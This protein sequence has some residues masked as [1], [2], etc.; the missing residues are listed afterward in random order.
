MYITFDGGEG[1]GKTTLIGRLAQTLANTEPTTD[2][3][4]LKAIGQGELG[5]H[6]R[7]AF[8][9]RELTDLEATAG[10][11]M[12]LLRVSRMAREI[13][14]ET[15]KEIYVLQDRALPAFYAIDV[16]G[17]ISKFDK[18]AF[19]CSAY[20]NTLW[21]EVKQPDLAVYLRLSPEQA[22]KN[23]TNRKNQNWLDNLPTEEHQLILDNY[24]YFFINGRQDQGTPWHRVPSLVLDAGLPM[25]DLM[26]NA[27]ETIKHIQMNK[28]IFEN[29]ESIKKLAAEE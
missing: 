29:H 28:L 22:Q 13:E 16:N 20:V 14:K 3:H 19:A 4:V 5:H 25:D 26:H 24:D 27:M 6:F 9:N 1:S 11:V 15:G 17:P 8:L 7:N 10:K 21:N 23:I 12:E 18:T 2:V